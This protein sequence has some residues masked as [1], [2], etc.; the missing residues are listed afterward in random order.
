MKKQVI[1]PEHPFFNVKQGRTVPAFNSGHTLLNSFRLFD[2]AIFKP[3]RNLDN[4][5]WFV[6]KIVNW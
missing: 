2:L 4:P 6:R 3:D 1:H 5:L